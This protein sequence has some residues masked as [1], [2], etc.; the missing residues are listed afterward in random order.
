MYGP[1]LAEFHKALKAQAL[2][3]LRAQP[4][5]RPG[6]QPRPPTTGP[7]GRKR[8]DA[9]A[10][11]V[12]L[13]LPGTRSA[14]TVLGPVGIGGMGEVYRARD[15]RLGRDVALKVLQAGPASNRTSPSDCFVRPG[16]RRHSIIRTSVR[17]STS[18][19]ITACRS[20]SW[21]CWRGDTRPPDRPAASSYHRRGEDRHADCLGP[22]GRPWE[23]NRP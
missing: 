23:R 5:E 3:E 18:A 16:R 7:R 10:I 21:S 4:L 15:S 9:L 11:F 20:S 1:Y 19:T 8:Y 12:M 14:R 17:S 2:A 13:L 6:R 22:R